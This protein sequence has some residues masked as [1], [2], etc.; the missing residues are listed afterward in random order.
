MEQFAQHL[1][2]LQRRL[3]LDRLAL[4][5]GGVAYP[6]DQVELLRDPDTNLCLESGIV[7]LGREVVLVRRRQPGDVVKVSDQ[8][9]D[10][11]ATVEARSCRVARQI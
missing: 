7:D 4:V 9:L 8:L 1:Q 2:H 5:G 10:R 6:A 11:P 3:R